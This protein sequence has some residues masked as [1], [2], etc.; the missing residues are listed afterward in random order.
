MPAVLAA[1]AEAAGRAG[2]GAEAELPVVVGAQPPRAEAS[3]ASEIAQSLFIMILI[4]GRAIIPLATA[5]RKG[6]LAC[7]S[8]D[9]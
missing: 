3:R 6:W 2:A 5:T 8:Y 4:G 7:E 1:I 9:P